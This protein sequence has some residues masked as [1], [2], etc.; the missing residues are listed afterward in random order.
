[1]LI[2]ELVNDLQLAHKEEGDRL[3]DVLKNSRE[4]PALRPTAASTNADG[5]R[6]GGSP[7]S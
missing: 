6:E 3:K 7:G 1:M 4:Q 5:T 2:G